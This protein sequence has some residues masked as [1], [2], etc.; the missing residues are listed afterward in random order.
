[1]T[2]AEFLLEFLVVALDDP[3]MFGQAHQ[4]SKLVSA[5]SVESQYLVGADSELGH[6][7]SNHSSARGSLIQ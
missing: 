5:G 6:S 4:V 1:M 2:E 3:T 7:I